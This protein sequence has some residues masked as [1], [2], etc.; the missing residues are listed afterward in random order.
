MS[1]LALLG[2]APQM[3]QQYTTNR[4]GTGMKR[5]LEYRKLSKSSSLTPSSFGESFA[6][7]V[8]AQYALPVGTG[9]AALFAAVVAAGVEP[10]DEVIVVSFTWL[11]S[12]S[13]ILLAN[14]I[15]V[16]ADIDEKTFTIDPEDVIRKIN[17]RTKAILAVDIYGHP[18]PLY[19]LKKIVQQ[20][21]LVLIEDAAQATGARIDNAV[22][23]GVADITTFSFA[24][25]PLTSSSGGILTTN[26]KSYFE[27]AA[28]VGQ[29]PMALSFIINDPNL[30]KYISTGYGDNHRI[31]T[32]ALI[33][34]SENF[35]MMNESTDARIK[36]ANYLTSE[37]QEIEGITPPYTRPNVRHVFHIYTCLY[38]EKY[39]GV[40]RSLFLQALRAEG[41]IVWTYIDGSDYLFDPIGRERITAGPLHYRSIFQEKNLYGKGC[42]FQ[43]PHGVCPSYDIGSLPVTERIAQQEFNLM[44]DSISPPNDIEDMKKY[45]AA[46]R[47]VI[48]NMDELKYLKT[49]R[50]NM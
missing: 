46:I 2:G 27:K 38:D 4:Q 6:S 34:A 24:G 47:K 20:H 29:H 31:D 13:A 28:L 19:D 12:V 14:G 33:L 5:L 26:E 8:G 18:A 44:Q 7:Y 35:K 15:P 3:K 50:R 21:N 17:K 30:R 41:M 37:L 25:K 22:V 39:F 32:H 40:P 49:K 43:C 16:F 1:K 11:A 36:N 23:G 42:P 48:D 9:T 45:V 10:G